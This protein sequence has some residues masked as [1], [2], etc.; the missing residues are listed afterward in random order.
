MELKNS[1]LKYLLLLFLS[2][3]I[4]AVGIFILAHAKPGEKWIGWMGIIFS[5]LG[6][7]IILWQLIDSR[8][9]IVLNEN[10]ILDRTLGVGLIPWAEIAG[11]YIV[12]IWS[13]DFI[14]L[15]LHNPN[16]WVNN[17][18]LFKRLLVKANIALGCTEINL[19]LSGVKADASQVLELILKLSAPN[20]H[21][22]FQTDPTI[23]FVAAPINKIVFASS[24]KRFLIG[25]MQNR[26]TGFIQMLLGLAGIASCCGGPMMLAHRLDKTLGSTI[27]IGLCILPILLTMWGA[28]SLLDQR[29]IRK[30]D[31]FLVR[32]GLIGALIA[33]PIQI[34]GAFRL[35]G[36]ADH[37]TLIFHSIGICIGL[38][39]SIGYTC[40]AKRWP[41]RLAGRE[42]LPRH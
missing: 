10:G 7:P 40:A 23:D 13:N 36:I 16:M 3:G 6:I 33:I 39:A 9:R 42:R 14:C 31:L 17:L 30:F 38:I 15:R 32:A 29:D 12:S 18:S 41:A 25:N 4:V 8:P 27:A 37:P 34:W 28:F 20:N 5:G 19:N 35:S 1:R 22:R 11:A 2:C 21:A 26:D 24:F